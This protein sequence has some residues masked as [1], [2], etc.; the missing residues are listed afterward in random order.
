MQCNTTVARYHFVYNVLMEEARKIWVD[1]A[2]GQTTLNAVDGNVPQQ[3][4]AVRQTTTR[5]TL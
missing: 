5:L 2:Y 1:R 4:E 3:V